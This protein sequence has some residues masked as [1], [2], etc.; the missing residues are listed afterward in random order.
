MKLK[1]INSR[2]KKN[3]QYCV[4]NV[5]GKTIDKICIINYII[6]SIAIIFFSIIMIGIINNPLEPIATPTVIYI[7]VLTLP[8]LTYIIS[9]DGKRFKE[10]YTRVKQFTFVV[11][12]M[13]FFIFCYLVQLINT[14]T[15]K[16]FFSVEK[17]EI[18]PVE[19][20]LSNIKIM[21][22]LIPAALILPLAISSLKFIFDD[23]TKKAI[24]DFEVELLLPTVYKNDDT[25]IDLEL[26]KDYIT[27]EEC[28]LP[29][30]KS[31]EHLFLQGGT[32]SGKT[33]TVI[34]RLLK[35]I[36]YKKQYLQENEKQ[37]VYD[38]LEKGLLVLNGPYTSEYINN[39]FSMEMVE[40]VDGKEK[41]FQEVFKKYIIG[42][43]KR[44]NKIIYKDVGVTIISPDG[45][46]AQETIELGKLFNIKVHKIDPNLD[47]IE[48]GHIAC[49][50]P[51]AGG[52]PDKV[53]DIISSILVSMDS[54]G[55]NSKNN[56]YFVNAS[57]RA[58]RNLTILLKIMYPIMYKKEPTLVDVLS[59]LNNFNSVVPI[60][61]E[62]KRHQE[63]KSNL[64][65]VIQYFETSFYPPE[66]DERGKPL[67]GTTI[68]S[69]R[70][71]TE[72]AVSGIIN[73]LDN[74]IGRPEIRSILCNT[75]K[76]SIDFK[77][78]LANGECVAIS[79]RQN[80]LGARLGRAF[81]LF[82][83][84]SLQNEVLSRYAED[85]EPEK[86]HYIFIDEFPMYLND[87]TKTFFT[88][89]RKYKCS[90]TSAIQNMAQLKEVSEP[91][92]ET[93]FTNTSTKV[94]LSGSN[95]E[96]REYW[97]KFFGT[98]EAVTL[99]TGISRGTLSTDNPKNTQTIKGKFS[100]KPIVSEQD[101]DNLLFKQ[102]FYQYTNFKGRKCTGK[103]ITDFSHD[104]KMPK[105]EIKNLDFTPFVIDGETYLDKNKDN[106]EKCDKIDIGAE[107]ID[108]SNINLIDDGDIVTI[109][110]LSEIS[111]NTILPET[112]SYN[113]IN[114]MFN[115][116]NVEEMFGYQKNETSNDEYFRVEGDIKE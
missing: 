67:P 53:G 49:F 87:N 93:I 3:I 71:K 92:R 33:S 113:E 97:S 91:F 104:I 9:I 48:K 27:G 24:R 62:M 100:D 68:G 14:T 4:D 59:S 47:E 20:I 51:L 74:F 35:Q 26:C 46:L 83:I 102:T 17:I 99:E 2:I 44:E 1:K 30:K 77:S 112:L 40:V 103:G 42:A 98:K 58:V 23:E 56:P 107:E 111:K 54:E 34:K 6:L 28:I 57:V 39:N 10:S 78:I 75:S 86:P 13:I 80:E 81:A 11:S 45:G 115:D 25:T 106:E 76:E 38:C 89:S 79:T 72:D 5:S 94:L 50:N 8:L 96:D 66:L 12:S 41:E 31:F 70:S 64:S 101:I 15:N 18:I 114:E 82:F 85:E 88:F 22:F 69:K 105:I 16:L 108:F 32:G 7:I 21:T 60:V 73:Q 52:R 55:D 19:F 43:R 61:E 29:E 65:S 84:L 109:D 110:D 36:F 63:L 116:E 90:V 37:L 95:V